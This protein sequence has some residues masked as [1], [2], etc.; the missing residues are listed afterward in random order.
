MLRGI[1]QNIIHKL[2]DEG[3]HELDQE[4]SFLELLSVLDK[5]IDE[6]SSRLDELRSVSESASYTFFIF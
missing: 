2:N 4:M 3:Q 5:E 6:R 1:V